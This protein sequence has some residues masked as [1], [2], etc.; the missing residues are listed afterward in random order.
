MNK[1]L[2]YTL[3]IAG[4]ILSLLILVWILIGGYVLFNKASILQKARSELNKRVNGEALIGDIDIS[5]FRHFPE[6]SLHFT[7]VALHDSLWPQHHHDMLNAEHVFVRL[8]FFSLFT[9]H[10]RV[11]KVFIQ[12]GVIYLFTDSMGYSNT[13]LLRDLITRE[14]PEGVQG[15]K[16]AGGKPVPALSLSNSQFILENLDRRKLFHFNISHLDLLVKND[17]S[18]DNTKNLLL[19][20]DLDLLVKNF[21]LNTEKGSFLKDKPLIGRFTLG[22]NTGSKIIQAKEITLKIDGDP[23]RFSARFFPA[24]SPDPFN[25]TIQT[26]PI[27]YRKITSLLT[28]ALREKLDQYD[29]DNPVSVNALID[30]GSADDPKPL[31]NVGLTLEKGTITTPVGR[32][33]NASFKGSFTN[34]WVHRQPREDENSGIRLLSFTGSWENIPLKADTLSITNLRMPVLDCDLHS[35]FGLSQ[36]NELSGSKTLQLQKGSCTLNLSYKGP[37]SANDSTVASI[38]GRIDLDSA[39]INYIPYGLLLT[40]GT[41]RIHFKDQD[42]F[43]DQLEARA[44]SS[45]ILLKGNIINLVTLIDRDPENLNMN[46]NL[47][48]PHLD[49]QDFTAIA[50]KPVETANAAG[51]GTGGAGAAAS[52]RKKKV[53][54]QTVSARV[55]RFLQDGVIRLQLEAA[56]IHYQK[57]SG[58]HAKA[59]ILFSNKEIQLNKL[60]VEQKTGSLSLSATIRR[61]Q[62]STNNPFSLQSHLEQVDLPELFRSFNNFGQKGLVDKNLKGRLTADAK[63]TGRLNYKAEIVNKS[64]K[65]TVIFSIKDGQLLNYEP[66]AKIQESFLKNRDLSEIRFAELKNQLDLDSTTLYIHRMEIQSTA[67]SLFTEGFYDWK[68]GADLSIQVPLSNLKKRKT[69]NPLTN[70]GTNSKTGVSLRLRAKTGEDGK[71]NISWDPFKKALK[72]SP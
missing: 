58:A 34:E 69:D 36:L 3:R 23:F 37:L 33:T 2:R 11:N 54:F 21:C 6:I 12:Q 42:F 68:K 64:L 26:D 22:F 28:P 1:T 46:L 52:V 39:A 8:S 32:F 72:K 5:L 53:P 4:G 19:Q 27:S 55:D 47:S 65:G 31:I 7:K 16:E 66:M 51:A 63:M 48:S 10:P 14:K 59:N 62:N 41:G 57:F 13:S 9:G 43:I 60:E 17:K 15:G 20:L 44:G 24:V 25:L 38:N 50:G 49:L 56:D 35:S 45:K 71:L 70:K 61:L 30:A 29:I 40:G 18:G 67:F